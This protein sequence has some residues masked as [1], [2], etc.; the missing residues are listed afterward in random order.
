LNRWRKRYQE[1]NIKIALFKSSVLEKGR[2]FLFV[3]TGVVRSLHLTSFTN[4]PSLELK[5]DECHDSIVLFYRF[6]L[7]RFVETE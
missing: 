4:T 6:L 5:N 7:F 2:G 1:R 3:A